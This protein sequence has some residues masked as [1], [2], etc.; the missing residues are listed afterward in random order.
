MQIRVEINTKLL[1][2]IINSVPTLVPLCPIFSYIPKIG[3]PTLA[4][5]PTPLPPI[6]LTIPMR[7]ADDFSYD[8]MFVS[9]AGIS[10]FLGLFVKYFT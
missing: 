10:E 5:I 7:K 1:P 6:L 3:H 8:I 9:W 4:N 2:I